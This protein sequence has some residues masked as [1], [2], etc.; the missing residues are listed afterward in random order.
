MARVRV[1]VSAVEPVMDWRDVHG[2]ARAFVYALVGASEPGLAQQLHDEGWRGS[3]LRPVGISP[4]LFLGAARQ[5]GVY[6]TSADGS[7][8]LG[9]P[10]PQL[11]AAMLKGLAGRKEVRWGAARLMVRGTELEWPTDFGAGRAD[12][13]SVSPV[14]VKKESRFLMPD[15]P[16]YA[17]RLTH[18]LRHKADLLGIPSDVGVEILDAGPRRV[19]DVA[20]AKRAGANVRLRIT[21]APRLLGAL[22]EWGVGLNTVQGFGWLR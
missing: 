14:L 16:G 9:S 17:E 4:P 13:V 1:D 19:F 3:T 21:A 5:H 6:T 8:W 11:A 10:V 22:Y 18:N 20:G 15:D 2:P 12:F 7:I